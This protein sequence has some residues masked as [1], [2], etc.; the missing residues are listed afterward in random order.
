M[1]QPL[2]DERA[3]SNSNNSIGTFGTFDEQCLYGKHFAVNCGYQK[4]P[5]GKQTRTKTCNFCNKCQKYICTDCFEMYHTKSN[6][7]KNIFDQGENN[8]EM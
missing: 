6:P 7:K 3:D 2:L 5:D 1:V 4:G 8:F